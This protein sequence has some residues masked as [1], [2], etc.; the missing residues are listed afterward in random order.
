[1]RRTRRFFFIIPKYRSRIAS[2]SFSLSLFGSSGPG[3]GPDPDPGPGRLLRDGSSFS[4]RS[5][6]RCL[7]S[8]SR[9]L[10]L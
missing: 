7:R 4:S 1:M 6:S 9:S 8:L 10:S 2:I 5:L 3:P